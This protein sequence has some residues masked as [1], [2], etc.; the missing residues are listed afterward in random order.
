VGRQARVCAVTVAARA[1]ASP[2]RGPIIGYRGVRPVYL[3]DR[4][5]GPGRF[6]DPEP[7][8]QDGKKPRKSAASSGIKP[9]SSSPYCSKT[10]TINQRVSKALAKFEAAVAAGCLTWLT[11]TALMKKLAPDATDHEVQ[12]LV[13]RHLTGMKRWSARQGEAFEAGWSLE[14]RG[15][16]DLHVHVV[17]AC[18]PRLATKA[19]AAVTENLSRLTGKKVRCPRLKFHCRRA[20]VAS[21]NQARG[22]WMYKQKSAVRAG[23][24]VHGIKGELHQSVAAKPRG[25]VRAAA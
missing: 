16:L 2:E 1:P 22:W 20:G 8:P 13:A 11:F 6:R 17:M 23:E 24:I 14:R 15:R 10:S 21:A 19:R 12:Q 25:W 7:A 4:Q 3:F 9:R 18:S 5:P